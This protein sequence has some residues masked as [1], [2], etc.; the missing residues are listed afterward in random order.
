MVGRAISTVNQRFGRRALVWAA[1][2]AALALLL[3]FVPLLDLLSYDFSFAVGLA[4]ALAAV[5]VG[6]GV[7]TSARAAAQVAPPSE[8]RPMP[9]PALLVGR[10]LAG[11]LGVLVAPLLLSMLN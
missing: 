10:A 11:G 6:Q 1:I 7:V 9:G 4:A 2:L 5:D 8:P 3:D